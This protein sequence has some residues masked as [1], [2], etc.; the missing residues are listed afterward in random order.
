MHN[1][2]DILREISKRLET[3]GIAYMLTGSM[4]LNYYAQ[5]RMTRDL[6]LVVRL[7]ESDVDRLIAIFES[8][9]Y[10]DHQTVQRA[11]A[12]HRMF[13]V[14]HYDSVIKVDFI[15]LRKDPYRQEEFDRRQ[16][17]TI[18]DFQIWIVSLEDLVL[19]KLFWSRESRSELQLRDVHNLLMVPFD[20][21]YIERQARRLN[22]EELLEEALNES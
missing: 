15:V 8:D 6:D 13:N 21:D 2:L 10:I 17:V 18:G 4:A 9:F 1:E 7:S 22:I 3:A 5:P 20:R 16:R 14:I 19:S 11:V 12:T